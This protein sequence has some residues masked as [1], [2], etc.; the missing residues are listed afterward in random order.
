MQQPAQRLITM[1]ADRPQDDTAYRLHPIW[2]ARPRSEWDKTQQQL[3][4]LCI[5]EDNAL[6]DCASLREAATNMKVYMA[7][8]LHPTYQEQVIMHASAAI[9]RTH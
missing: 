1:R 6:Q 8:Q 5:V 9:F 7:A 4:R 2:V 3:A